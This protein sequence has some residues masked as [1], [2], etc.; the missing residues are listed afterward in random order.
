MKGTIALLTICIF[1]LFS[2]KT[3]TTKENIKNSESI[4]N[5]L[6]SVD[7]PGI[8]SGSLPCQGCN[9]IYTKLLL[10]K[11]NTFKLERIYLG[12]SDQVLQSEGTFVW[13]Q[14]GEVITLNNENIKLR[15]LD[16]KLIQ[17]DPNGNRYGGE[18]ANR[19]QLIMIDLLAGQTWQLTQL[20]G[21]EIA[22]ENFNTVPFLQFDSQNKK[23]SGNGGCN[24]FN[25]SYTT[26][27]NDL[28]FGPLLSTKMACAELNIE[29]SL[30]NALQ[31][32]ETFSVVENKLTIY[33]K[34]Q[35]PL[36][37]FTAARKR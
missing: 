3:Q 22:V 27:A 28:H 11:D 20:N 1:A 26:S 18:D 30:M 36:A 31:E 35:T 9:G 7:W 13:D 19:Y 32:T 37:V 25:G 33:S 29:T 14:G 12:K 8:Y 4:H 5:T 21:N 34:D 17:L 24:T 23:I 2:C 6:K 10:K 15:V 16:K